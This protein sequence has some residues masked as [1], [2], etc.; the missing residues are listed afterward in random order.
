MQRA[1]QITSRNF[2]LTAAIRTTIEQHAKALEQYFGRLTG[3]HVVLEAPA[4]HHHRHGG[5]FK[6]SIDL[7]TPQA[8]ISIN[9]QQAQD[10]PVA[11]REAFD[12]ARRRLEDHLRELRGDVKSH[13]STR[14][15]AGEREVPVEDEE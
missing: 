12:A 11:I 8:E 1:L 13:T 6:V 2:E 3:C 14:R 5:P 9:K 7:R 4:V 10:L 15:V